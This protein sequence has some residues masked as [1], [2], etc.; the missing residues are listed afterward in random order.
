MS[1]TMTKAEQEFDIL[2]QTNKEAIVLEFKNEILA[3][4]NKFGNSGQSGG[5]APYVSQIIS[6]VVK[7]LC[8]QQSI[9]PIMGTDDEWNDVSEISD[10][11]IGTIFQNKRNSAIFKDNTGAYYLDAIVFEGENGNRF[12]SGSVDLPEKEK[13]ING[14]KIGSSQYIKEFP[15]EPKTFYI[16]VIETEWADKEQTKQK[17]GGGWWTSIIKDETQLN[18][19]FEYYKTPNGFEKTEVRGQ[20]NH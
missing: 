11:K 10:E 1:K 6:N 18:D 12:T 4:V 7:K 2:E 9:S 19:V 20:L 5:S 15:F 17:N 3:L 14:L 13:T 16:N 8:M